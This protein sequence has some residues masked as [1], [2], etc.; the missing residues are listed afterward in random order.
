[1]MIRIITNHESVNHC[2]DDNDDHAGQRSIRAEG[3]S[4]LHDCDDDQR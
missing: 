3:A 1:M 2:C 4:E